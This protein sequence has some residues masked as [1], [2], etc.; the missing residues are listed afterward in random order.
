MGP[1]LM[2]C[3]TLFWKVF[4][5]FKNRNIYSLER[6][7]WRMVCAATAGVASRASEGWDGSISED[8]D[9]FCW[10]LL[11]KAPKGWWFSK[12]SVP[13][14]RPKQ[15]RFRHYRDLPR[16]VA[17]VSWNHGVSMMVT[18][19]WFLKSPKNTKLPMIQRNVLAYPTRWALVA[20]NGVMGLLSVGLYPQLPSYFRRPITP[21]ILGGLIP[22]R[23]RG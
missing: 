23:I 12:R 16:T 19:W 22:G 3:R 21:S 6:P 13:Q 8:F 11:G 20:I 9:Q 7:W 18:A 14:N 4:F 5:C 1:V 2:A 17:T 15:F 10:L